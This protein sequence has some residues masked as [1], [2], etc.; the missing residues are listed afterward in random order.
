MQ[1]Q[2][3]KKIYEIPPAKRKETEIY[4]TQEKTR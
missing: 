2:Y 3:L 1:N 4:Q